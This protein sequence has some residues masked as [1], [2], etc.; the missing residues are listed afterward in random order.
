MPMLDRMHPGY[1]RSP[2]AER[3]PLAKVTN[4]LLDHDGV[5]QQREGPTERKR[6]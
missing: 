3:E 4:L 2:R 1:A 5:T 6:R